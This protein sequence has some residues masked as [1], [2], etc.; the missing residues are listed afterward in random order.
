ME[1]TRMAE[2]APAKVAGSGAE[3]DTARD[4][5][6]AAAEP[7]NPVIPPPASENLELRRRQEKEDAAR[8]ES[9]GDLPDGQRAEDVISDPPTAED[10]DRVAAAALRR[11]DAADGEDDQKTAR[12]AAPQGRS[13]K[14]TEKA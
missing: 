13:A 10:R 9:I 5:K 11:A 14:P 2:N 7:V 8:R 4:T 12:S 6:D 1:E 3:K